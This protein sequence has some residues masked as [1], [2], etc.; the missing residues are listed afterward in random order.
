MQKSKNVLLMLT[1]EERENVQGFIQRRLKTLDTTQINDL[2]ALSQMSKQFVRRWQLDK[3]QYVRSS[4]RAG[5]L[6]V[7]LHDVALLDLQNLIK[8][9]DK[10]THELNI[11]AQKDQKDGKQDK[12]SDI[13]QKTE[14]LIMTFDDEELQH[15][16]DYIKDR[17]NDLRTPD[18]KTFRDACQEIITW[19]ESERGQVESLHMDQVGNINTG[20]GRLAIRQKRDEYQESVFNPLKTFFREINT[21]YQR[22]A[23]ESADKARIQAQRAK[24]MA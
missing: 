21:S 19:W 17:V 8:G 13:D 12:K 10:T 20:S 4:T 5:K 14:D 16:S 22:A 3:N 9:L 15:A 7:K 24:N 1:A 11:K 6:M 18:L 2:Q 23:K